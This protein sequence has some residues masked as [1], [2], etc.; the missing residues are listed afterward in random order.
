VTNVGFHDIDYHDSDGNGNVTFSGTDWVGAVAGGQITWACE[1]QSANNNAN[2]IRWSTLYNFYF[3]ADRAPVVGATTFGMW[4][5]GTPT[6]LS[7]VG[8]VPGQSF[9]SSF[10]FGDGSS[11]ACPCGN[12]GSAG[13]GCANSVHSGGAS[14]VGSGNASASYDAAQL[15]A[16]DVTGAVGIFFQGSLQDPP[17]ILDDG[18]GCVGG[19]I[20]RIG[21][22]PVGFG[23]SVYPEV[24]DPPITVRGAIPPSGG[25]F[26]YQCFYRNSVVAFCPPATSNRTNG[27]AITWIP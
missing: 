21:N 23:A 19:V 14:L 1:P 7:A 18:I 22:S 12:N 10:C 27:V 6:T 20:V 13:N 26:F 16:N 17:A 15:A 2:A 11:L 3:D 9:F 5:P 25:T 4:K 8:D 24:G